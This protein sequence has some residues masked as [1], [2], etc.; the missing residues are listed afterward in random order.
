VLACLGLLHTPFAYA[1]L[2]L[3]QARQQAYTRD[4][5]LQALS[6][7]QSI[8]PLRIAQ[9]GRLANPE[10]TVELDN[11]GGT[12]GTTN[13]GASLEW[14]YSQAF[15]LNNKRALRVN[16]AQ[17]EPLNTQLALQARRAALAAD[18]RVCLARWAMADAQVG[19]LTDEQ[20]VAQAQARLLGERL[21]A[22]KIIPSDHQRAVALVQEADAQRVAQQRM[23][24][25][26]RASCEGLVG[27]ALPEQPIPLSDDQPVLTSQVLL[28]E[29]QAEL[30][31]AHAR[32]RLALTT[33]ER[34]PDVTMSI[35]TRRSQQRSD[36]VWLVGATVPLTVFDPNTVARAVSQ[37]Q[38][39]Q[40]VAVATLTRQRALL[41]VEQAQAQRLAAQQQLD[42]LQQQVLPATQNSLRIAEMAYQA[43]KTGLLDWLEARQVWRAARE[44]ALQREFAVQQA[45]ADL[46][47]EFVISPAA[48]LGLQP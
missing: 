29:Q 14:R 39:D 7:R 35:G 44:R 16:L 5:E 17:I 30:D 38:L 4:P 27:A 11:L 1:D 21:R 33:A 24:H 47:R 36:Q 19:L 13:E 20:S 25:S 41:R 37:Q 9:A 3:E 46:E 31:I 18:V 10:V 40:A 8:D 32:A 6:Q 22:G 48:A 15:A 26:L 34:R 12:S 23:T 42:V 2:S 45:I 43:G 28:S